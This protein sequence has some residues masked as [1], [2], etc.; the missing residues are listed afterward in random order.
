MAARAG[1]AERTRLRIIEA[2]S[3]LHDE[4][5]IGGTTLRDIASR[6]DVA[7]GTIYHH[8][9]TYDAIIAAC[10]QH[11]MALL[12]PPA[13]TLLDGIRNRE[14]RLRILVREIFAFY[15]RA[16]FLGR[17]SA[18][19][20]AFQPVD[21][22]Y[23]QQEDTRRALVLTALGRAAP[24]RLR[25]LAFALLDFNTYESLRSSGLTQRIAT[26]EITNLLLTRS[27]R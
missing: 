11:T 19:R 17:F 24:K 21:A 12:H 5:G 13:A 8:F 20:Y 7:L 25:A 14:E 22:W 15:A 10:G 18:E 4:K 16:P 2:T 23:R 6:A 1:S 3:Q 27:R 26:E 9:P